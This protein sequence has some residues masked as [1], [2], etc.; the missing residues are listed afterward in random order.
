MRYSVLTRLSGSLQNMLKQ[1]ELQKEQESHH[2]N[3]EM[4]RLL[5]HFL[6]QLLQE[7][8]Q[9]SMVR[10]TPTGWQQPIIFNGVQLALTGTAPLSIL[11]EAVLL[12]LQ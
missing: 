7:T 12:Q 5:L 4:T 10:L 9:Q 3:L 8:V 11:P 1:E 2:L 6:Q